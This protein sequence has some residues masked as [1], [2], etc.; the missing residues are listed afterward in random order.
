MATK[1]VCCEAIRRCGDERLPGCRAED[2]AEI[3]TCTDVLAEVADLFC[4]GI[5]I[6]AISGHPVQSSALGIQ[7]LIDRLG[8][9]GISAPLSLTT[10]RAFAAVGYVALKTHSAFARYFLVSAIKFVLYPDLTLEPLSPDSCGSLQGMRAIDAAT[11]VSHLNRVY[12]GQ[13]GVDADLL[14]A[15]DIPSRTRTSCR[16][17][18]GQ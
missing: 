7:M 18:S 17:M 9:T 13:L 3:R 10:E 6:T 14:A 16:S 11:K 12:V 8:N 2:L 1:Y 4:A 5:A 15:A